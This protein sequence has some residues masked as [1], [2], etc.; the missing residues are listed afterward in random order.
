MRLLLPSLAVCSLGCFQCVL[1][2]QMD[3]EFA[4]SVKDWTTKPEF[5]S[6]LVD[7]LPKGGAVPSPKDVLGYHIGAPKKLTYYTDILR[8]YRTLGSTSA[9]QTRAA[10]A[11]SSSSAPRSRSRISR[12]SANI[13]LSSPTRARSA[14]PMP[15]R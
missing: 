6:P 8:Y 11:L 1:A 10:S 13:W 7:H 5:M 9:K 15:A 2:Q 4:K 14:K 3:D 12:P